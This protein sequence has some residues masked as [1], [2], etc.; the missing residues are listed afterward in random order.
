MPITG[1]TCLEVGKYKMC[2][3]IIIDLSNVLYVA[4]SA[5]FKLWLLWE[6]SRKKNWDILQ[7]PRQSVSSYLTITGRSIIL[8]SCQPVGQW[9][10]AGGILS[11]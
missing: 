6:K 1:K 8:C 3:L 7:I 4:F 10:K 9:K 2:I 5:K 11:F